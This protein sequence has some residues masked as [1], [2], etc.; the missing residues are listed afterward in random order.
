MPIFSVKA[1][2]QV[3]AGLTIIAV[4][5]ALARA[6]R[7]GVDLLKTHQ[8][9]QGGFAD[10]RILRE[11]RLRMIQQHFRPGAR[12]AIQLMDMDQDLSLTPETARPPA[13]QRLTA[14]ERGFD[15]LDQSAIFKVLDV[16]DA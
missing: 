8:A 10:V 13:A 16:A 12:I 6:S 14:A 1:A 2:N 5:E 9:L 4:A 3:V 15:Q 7:A 11:H